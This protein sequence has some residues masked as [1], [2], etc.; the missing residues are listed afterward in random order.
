MHTPVGAYIFQHSSLPPNHMILLPPST[1]EDFR[2]MLPEHLP[3][4]L[5]ILW[6]WKEQWRGQYGDM[7]S[8]C[9]SPSNWLFGFLEPLSPYAL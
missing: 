8:R 5:Y 7:G 6:H 1:L 3:G 9:G 4:I 2:L